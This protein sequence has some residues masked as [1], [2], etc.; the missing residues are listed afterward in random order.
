MKRIILLLPKNLV[1]NIFISI[2]YYKHIK[3]VSRNLIEKSFLSLGEINES[4]YLGEDIIF[5]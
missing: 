2:F 3:F 4:F 5:A 1:Q